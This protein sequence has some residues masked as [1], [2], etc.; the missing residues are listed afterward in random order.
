M[1]NSELVLEWLFWISIVLS[2]PL[3]AISLM[4]VGKHV[5]ALQYQAAKKL[6]G[7]RWIQSWT[8]LRIHFNRVIF[9]AVFLYTSVLGVINADIIFRTW[10]GRVGFI[11]VLLIFLISSVYDWIAEQKQL[12]ILFKYEEINNLA[13][14][15]VELHK[16]NNKLA[17]YYG[18]VE[19][20]SKTPEQTTELS[21]LEDEIKALVRTIQGDV[22]SM[23]PSYKGI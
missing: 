19:L 11:F 14:I 22:H 17:I 9:A 21:V 8:N 12:Q 13:S 6:N 10:A 18:M 16:L 4:A 2:M 5:D 7:I 20:M 23:D 3:L 15:R 1:D